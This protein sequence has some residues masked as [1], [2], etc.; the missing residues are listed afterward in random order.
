VQTSERPEG[1]GAIAH[2]VVIIGAGLAG[3]RVAEELRRAGYTGE[4]TLLGSERHLPYDRP[5]LSKEVMRGEREDTTLKP[6]GFFEENR[7]GLRLGVAASCVNT[8]RKLVALADG[9]VIGYDDLVIATGLRPRRPRGLPALEGVHVLRTFDD[10]LALRADLRASN[11]VLVV[12]AGFIGCELAASF[13]TVGREVVLIDVQ[14]APLAAV[15]GQDVGRLVERLHRAE[16]VDVRGGI[17]LGS[18]TGNGRVSGAVLTDGSELEVDLVV[19]GVG[20]D[21]VTGWLADS[22]IR[23]ADPAAGGGVL[24]DECGRTSVE[25]VWATGDVAAWLNAAGE[26]RRIEHWSNASDQA[27]VLVK[28]LLGNDAPRIT[29]VPYFWS[30]QYDVKIQAFGTPSSQDIVHLVEDDGRKFLAV[31]ESGGHL[32]AVIGAGKPREVMKLRTK[33]AAAAPIEDV[34]TRH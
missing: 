1:A 14:S 13:R 2:R 18:L 33:V 26:H 15:F 25:D 6:R 29:Q 31:Y 27:K 4:I 30:D 7:I 10:M 3:L 5:P 23:L 22:G 11:R 24:T 21:P 19:L 17:G 8:A 28:A 12:G 9:T 34:I 32:T 20:S 16:G